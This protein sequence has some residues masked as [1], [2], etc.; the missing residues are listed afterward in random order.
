MAEQTA[1]KTEGTTAK[2]AEA[3]EAPEAAHDLASKAREALSQVLETGVKGARKAQEYGELAITWLREDS[4]EAVKAQASSAKETAVTQGKKM[5]EAIEKTVTTIEERFEPVN[6]KLPS[7]A[8]DMVKRGQ[9]QAREARAKL[10]ERMS[11]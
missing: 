5:D 7:K 10:R 4:I 3:P 8:Q 1:K 2:A 6:T 11:A 9:N